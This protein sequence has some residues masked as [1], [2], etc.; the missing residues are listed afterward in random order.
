MNRCKDC[1][2]KKTCKKYKNDGSFACKDFEPKTEQNDF[3]HEL[4]ETLSGALIE[5]LMLDGTPRHVA[6]EIVLGLGEWKFRYGEKTMDKKRF[7]LKDY[8]DVKYCMSFKNR[9]EYDSFCRFLDDNGRYW[10]SGSRYWYTDLG[11]YTRGRVLCFNKGTTTYVS[12]AIDNNYAVLKYSDFDWSEKPTL[13]EY[14]DRYGVY[15][16]QDEDGTRFSYTNSKPIALHKQWDFTDY[17]ICED[18]TDET[19]PFDGNWKNSLC[20]PSKETS[21][22]EKLDKANDKIEKLE[23]KLEKAKDISRHI[24]YKILDRLLNAR[25]LDSKDLD[26]L[27][28]NSK[29]IELQI[30]IQKGNAPTI[31]VEKVKHGSET[32][33]DKNRLEIRVEDMLSLSF[34]LEDLKINLKSVSGETTWDARSIYNFELEVLVANAIININCSME[35]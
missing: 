22:Y 13:Q 27:L 29:D 4:L 18:I 12:C 19:L 9:E 32:K 7:R 20:E 6:K 23:K 8:Q 28:S 1:S 3:F 14:A 10:N 25:R 35:K 26:Y 11:Q 16:A 24:E 30:D 31:S 34:S 33:I 17:S 5:S 2:K 21:L 15:T